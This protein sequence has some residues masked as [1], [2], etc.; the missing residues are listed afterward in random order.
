[1]DRSR[2]K[3]S[4]EQQESATFRCYFPVVV[5]GTEVFWGQRDALAVFVLYYQP[6]PLAR[7]SAA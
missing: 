1:M 6:E 2:L 5:A 3:N 7:R 4:Q